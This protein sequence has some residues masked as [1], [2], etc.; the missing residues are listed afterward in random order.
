MN[1]EYRMMNIEGDLNA[2]NQG[3]LLRYSTFS[4]R[5]SKQYMLP[6]NVALQSSILYRNSRPLKELRDPYRVDSIAITYP[7]IS[8]LLR[9]RSALGIVTK[10]RP[11]ELQVIQSNVAVRRYCL[12][13]P[14]SCSRLKGNCSVPYI[15]QF[16]FSYN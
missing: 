3:K 4:I 13:A 2:G 10:P 11:L 8:M 6:G 14:G 5:Y 1:V 16:P 12:Q 7:M 9:C 15:Y